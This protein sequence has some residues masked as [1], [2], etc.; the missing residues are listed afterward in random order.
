MPGFDSVAMLGRRLGKPGKAAPK[1]SNRVWGFTREF[2]CEFQ[3]MEWHEEK[4]HGSP[5]PE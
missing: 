1:P 5:H 4:D 3:K 2:R